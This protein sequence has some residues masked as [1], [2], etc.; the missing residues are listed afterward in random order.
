[1]EVKKYNK[2]MLIITI[3][4][5]FVGI[6][7]FLWG[8]AK[9]VAK[10]ENYNII[11]QT[12]NDCETTKKN[13]EMTIDSLKNSTTLISILEGES[14]SIINGKVLVTPDYYLSSSIKLKFVGADGISEKK[15]GNFSTLINYSYV[16]G[17]EQI[18]VKKDSSI[19]VVNILKIK[20]VT[21]ETTKI[22]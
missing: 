9:D 8:F 3:L 10:N 17:G 11:A 14:K 21:I 22:K 6:I 7:G 18:Y 16:S 5:F 1:M 4:S 2:K 15:D 12:L 20:P 13:L 19:W